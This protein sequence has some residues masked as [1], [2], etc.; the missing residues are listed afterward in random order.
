MIHRLN[1]EH[2]KKL[3]MYF[4]KFKGMKYWLKIKFSFN[5]KKNFI[6]SIS[7]YLNT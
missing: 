2:Q 1:P 6:K 7:V 3:L 5:S 4:L